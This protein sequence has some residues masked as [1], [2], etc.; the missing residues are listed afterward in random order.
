MEDIGILWSYMYILVEILLVLEKEI[1]LV[2]WQVPHDIHAMDIFWIQ[3]TCEL[4][5]F[6]LKLSK[7]VTY[8]Y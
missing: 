4:S 1:G 2:C 7:V 6:S 3:P 8:F 5:L